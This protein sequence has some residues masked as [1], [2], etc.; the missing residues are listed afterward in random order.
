MLDGLRFIVI[1]QC[2]QQ[3]CYDRNNKTRFYGIR[4]S[5]D[6]QCVLEFAR[7]KTCFEIARVECVLGLLEDRRVYLATD[8]FEVGRLSSYWEIARST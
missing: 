3:H 4:N 7:V 2:N 8:S 6:I 5:T 1:Q